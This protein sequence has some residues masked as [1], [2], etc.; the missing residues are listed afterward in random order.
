MLVAF[1]FPRKENRGRERLSS[2]FSITQ[3]INGGA[4][5][6]TQVNPTPDWTLLSYYIV[7]ERRP[8]CHSVTALTEENFYFPRDPQEKTIVMTNFP[9][10]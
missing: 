4:G 7:K 1:P 5:I 9:C 2:V 3:L 8:L 6:S 10:P